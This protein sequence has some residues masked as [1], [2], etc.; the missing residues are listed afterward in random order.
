MASPLEAAKKKV[1]VQDPNDEKSYLWQDAPDEPAAPGLPESAPPPTGQ[2]T[3]GVTKLPGGIQPVIGST[4]PMI[5]PK[6]PAPTVPGATVTPTVPGTGT[7]LRNTLITPEPSAGTAKATGLAETAAG[8]FA[9][10]GDLTK[11]GPQ[12]LKDYIDS[13][14]PQWEAEQ[15]SVGQKAAALGRTGSGITTTELG[16]LALQRQKDISTKASQLAG[17]L[18]PAQAQLLGSQLGGLAGYEGQKTGQDTSNAEQLRGER[19][20][21]SGM[22]QQDLDNLIREISLQDSLKS[23]E[24]NRNATTAGVNLAGG[25]ILSGQAGQQGQVGSDLLSQLSL[26]DYLKRLRG[27]TAAPGYAT[28]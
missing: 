5:L 7:D 27:Q 21:Q 10:A 18:A 28:A 26:E 12:L 3:P 2:P 8:N 25:G 14:N 20:Y 4:G 16:D 23:S 1:V 24:T 22:S 19:G 9:N 15:R 17:T 11:V 13:T 6:P